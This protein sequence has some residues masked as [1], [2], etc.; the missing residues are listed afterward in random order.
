MRSDVLLVPRE[1]DQ[2]VQPHEL[3]RVREAVEIVVRKEVGVPTVL[4]HPIRKAAEVR[5]HA[6][7]QERPCQPDGI[8]A[9]IGIPSVAKP[10]VVLVEQVVG[11]PGVRR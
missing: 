3:R 7:V 1:H 11:L 10:V 4:P 6:V 8:D 2:V 9:W 5:R